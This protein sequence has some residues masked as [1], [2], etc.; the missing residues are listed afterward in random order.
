MLLDLEGF[1]TRVAYDGPA[2]LEIAREFRPGAV[3]CDIGLPGM[4]GH[5]IARRLR[6]DPDIAPLRLIALT[7]WGAEGEIRR[8]RDSGFDFHLVKPVDANALIELLNLT[9]AA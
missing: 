8:T 5:E 2:A 9:D 6:S 4:D 1:D 3:V 7:G